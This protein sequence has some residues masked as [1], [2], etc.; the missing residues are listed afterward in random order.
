MF[1]FVI[2]DLNENTVFAARDP[3]GQK[4]LFYSQQGADLLVSSCPYPVNGDKL[5]STE[6]ISN[7]LY[8]G[9]II[10]CCSIYQNVFCLPPG[11][12]LFFNQNSLH[13]V[14]YDHPILELSLKRL[15]DLT[16]SDAIDLVDNALNDSV[17]RCLV[18]DVP[19]GLLLSGGIDSSL[20]LHYLK[21]NISDS[22]SCFTLDSNDSDSEFSLAYDY[23]DG[24]NL[25]RCTPDDFTSNDFLTTYGDIFSQPFPDSS[26]VYTSSLFKYVSATHKCVLSGD[27]GDEIFNGYNIRYDHL[28]PSLASQ[29]LYIRRLYSQLTSRISSQLP[30]SSFYHY[31][32]RYPIFATKHISRSLGRDISEISPNFTFPEHFRSLS[33]LD[34]VVL[35][36]YLNYLPFNINV[37]SDEISM[38]YGVESRSPF[39][40]INLRQIAFSLPNN[41]KS[42]FSH[43]KIILRNLHKT[44]FDKHSSLPKKGFGVNYSAFLRRP[45]LCAWEIHFTVVLAGFQLSHFRISN[46]FLPIIIHQPDGTLWLLPHGLNLIF[47]HVLCCYRHL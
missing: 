11:H 19:V 7:Y 21:Q 4:P 10:G 30:F 38:Y 47:K 14:K 39:Q 35:D 31:G 18:S 2:H 12:K 16:F 13:V 42:S 5:I 45:N 20:V 46:L 9:F 37:K 41:Y 24:E 15:S 27:G 32:F 28:Y 8:H 3:S 26:A 23:C 22:Y 40:D 36:D 6:A 43:S 44:R 33:Y 34:N 29:S 17:Q 1:S 25:F